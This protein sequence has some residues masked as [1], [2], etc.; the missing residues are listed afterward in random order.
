MTDVSDPRAGAAWPIPA[1]PREPWYRRTWT[2]LFVTL[3]VIGASVLLLLAVV[4][5]MG[6]GTSNS[7]QPF[8]LV[9]PS[10]DSG[11]GG[12]G[13][14]PLM[15]STSPA[16]N[17]LN[18]TATSGPA[19]GSGSPSASRTAPGAVAGATSASTTSP[20]HSDPTTAAPTTATT[21]AAA[22]LCGAPSNPW[23]YNQCG[24]G[25]LIYATPASFCS[26]FPCTRKFPHGNGYLIECNDGLYAMT[27]GK[28]DCAA[29]GGVEAMVYSG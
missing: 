9:K 1:P 25:S 27:G 22:S 6:V 17:V 21:T 11:L 12:P 4:S 26:Y 15:S 28:A 16:G 2:V 7:Q 3:T 24:R 8:G 19:S 14:G 29:N 23:G 18:G 20:A 10:G 5:G 13:P